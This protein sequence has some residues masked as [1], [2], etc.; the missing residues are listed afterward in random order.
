M[1]VQHNIEARSRNCCC[2]GKAV[3]IKYYECVYLIAAFSD[4][5]CQTAP[6]LAISSLTRY[7][8]R[9]KV[10]EQKIVF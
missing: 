9:E 10:I 4:V 5:A 1:Y 2:H 8:F 7:D 3:S 6:H